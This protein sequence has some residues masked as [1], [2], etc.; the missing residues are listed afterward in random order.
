[1]RPRRRFAGRGSSI[2]SGSAW[3][4]GA[5]SYFVARRDVGRCR[6]APA[7]VE[8]DSA[9]DLNGLMSALLEGELNINYLYAFIPHPH[10][11]SMLGLSMEDNEMA[12]QVLKRH[13]YRVLNQSDISR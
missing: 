3:T 7:L 9:T 13:R 10:G 4:G 1:M 8:V 12:E 11:K 2:G 5:V 6:F